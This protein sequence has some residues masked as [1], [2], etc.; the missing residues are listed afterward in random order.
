MKQT[1][2]RVLNKIQ[3][4][5]NPRK[6]RRARHI[7]KW[8][9]AAKRPLLVEE[10]AEAVAFHC[11]DTFWDSSKIP[12]ASSLVQVCGNLV[13]LDDDGTARFAHHTVHQFFI[14][15]PLE[16]SAKRFH[17]S[18]RNNDIHTG[19]ICMTYLFFSDFETQITLRPKDPVGQ[20]PSP[21]A[22]MAS[23]AAASGIGTLASG[24]LTA[25]GYLSP[26]RMQQQVTLDLAQ[27]IALKKPPPPDVSRKY[28]FLNY[29]IENWLSHTSTITEED[30]AWSKFKFLVLEK[31]AAFDVRPWGSEP[32]PC[33]ACCTWIHKTG[34]VGVLRAVL[35]YLDYT[36]SYYASYLRQFS[37]D[38]NCFITSAALHGHSDL[39][40]YLL[41]QGFVDEKDGT[42]LLKV[43]EI[44]NTT[45]AQVLLGLGLYI[46]HRP[47]ALYI[48]VKGW[49]V[50]MIFALLRDSHSISFEEHQE[51]E[52][53][54][55]AATRYDDDVLAL[56]Y[57]K[58]ESPGY[59]R[60]AIKAIW[61]EDPFREA[62]RHGMEKL[63]MSLF[64]TGPTDELGRQIW[65]AVN[66]GD[67]MATK[68]LVANALPEQLQHRKR[69]HTPLVQA[70]LQGQAPVVKI[71][72]ESGKL[73]LTA[74]TEDDEVGRISL[75]TAVEMGDIEMVQLLHE[76]GGL[77]LESRDRH[78]RTPLSHAAQ[79]AHKEM[80]SYM[81]HERSAVVASMDRCDRTP[82]S[83]AADMGHDQIVRLLQ[84]AEWV[85]SDTR[86]ITGRT[87][88]SYAAEGGH[89]PIVRFLLETGSVNPDMKD[90]T[91][92]TPFSYAAG[93]GHVRIIRLLLETKSV[94][95]DTRDN[96]GRTPLSHAAQYGH[97]RIVQ[98]LLQQRQVNPDSKDDHKRTPISWAAETGQ[99]EV[100]DCLLATGKVDPDSKDLDNTTPVTYA[101]RMGHTV[102]LHRLI[103]FETSTVDSKDRDLSSPLSWAA[104]AGDA[105]VAKILL[106]SGHV[107]VNSTN[108]EMQTPLC[109]AAKAGNEHIVELLL[110]VKEVSLE[111]RDIYGQ[112]PLSWAANQGHTEIVRL[113]LATGKVDPHSK[114]PHGLTAMEWAARKE[115]TDIVELLREGHKRPR[116]ESIQVL[117]KECC[118]GH[119]SGK[120]DYFPVEVLSVD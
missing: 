91:G 79:K 29:A 61:G 119:R 58:A 97:T 106:G 63:V 26:W 112:T 80:V 31:R 60:A 101:C 93:E 110:R 117:R 7:F 18:S 8:I 82:L 33:I 17:F 37:D 73:D 68:I 76:V 42:P 35:N 40:S 65:N 10:L 100:I 22:V 30:I 28:R 109:L 74:L 62:P 99:Y 64:R 56:L 48:A 36:H 95:S 71:L 98:I 114:D 66:D 20:L 45:A 90:N 102:I 25:W 120:V 11:T 3:R 14:G 67:V 34:N 47:D 83:Y 41:K 6:Q 70:V 21:V 72:L 103:K 39:L 27:V 111:C 9:A 92:R 77:S 12:D 24:F 104:A 81:V 51:K 54:D 46:D 53:L 44:G 2:T 52:L 113:L 38:G 69:G 19:Q 57:D 87:P 1:Y 84:D 43:V 85:N 86:D 23:V 13:V 107:S 4:N 59:M 105:S 16:D 118:S 96:T 108:R 89:D 5:L 15:L 116:D 55:Q 94:D 115:R 88:L 75:F 78:A 32:G 49:D 50:P